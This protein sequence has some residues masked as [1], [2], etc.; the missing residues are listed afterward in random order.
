MKWPVGD[1]SVRAESRLAMA[2]PLS[3]KLH[4]IPNVKSIHGTLGRQIL[5]TD[6]SPSPGCRR[7]NTVRVEADL[8]RIRD[9]EAF[10]RPWDVGR[11]PRRLVCDEIVV[12][13]T[14]L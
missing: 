14:L 8:Y 11:R 9:R 12:V 5:G 13:C 1:V 6:T 3:P 7:D 2:S 4:P 10:S